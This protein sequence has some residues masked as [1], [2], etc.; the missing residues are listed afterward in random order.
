TRWSR[1]IAHDS[2]RWPRCRLMLTDLRIQA[3]STF[4]LAHRTGHRPDDCAVGR[5]RGRLAERTREARHRR[6]SGLSTM[7]PTCAVR[8]SSARC[9]AE[10]VCKIDVVD[11]SQHGTRTGAHSA[12]WVDGVVDAHLLSGLESTT[13]TDP[14]TLPR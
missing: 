3:I 10:T 7:R 11:R 14:C 8:P 13:R 5:L 9:P 12:D 1:R 4:N 6:T 2:P